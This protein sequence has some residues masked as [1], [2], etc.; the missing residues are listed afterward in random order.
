MNPKDEYIGQV[1]K[2]KQKIGGKSALFFR[3][4][5]NNI[6]MQLLI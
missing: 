1:S 3:I 4:L 2:L 6:S 5:K